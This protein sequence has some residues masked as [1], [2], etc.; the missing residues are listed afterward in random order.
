MCVCVCVC[1][2]A[3]VCM[4]YLGIFPLSFFR[5]SQVK[6]LLN[7]SY[8]Y[9]CHSCNLGELCSVLHSLIT[10]SA[11]MISLCFK[12]RLC[13]IMVIVVF[14]LI[15]Q[16]SKKLCINYLFILSKLDSFGL[17]AAGV[18]LLAQHWKIPVLRTLRQKL[19]AKEKEPLEEETKL[20]GRSHHGFPHLHL[21]NAGHSRVVSVV[22]NTVL[23]GHHIMLLFYNALCLYSSHSPSLY[24]SFC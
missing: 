1:A 9:S 4:L 24:F 15:L 13:L 19:L 8:P 22:T 6:T 12:T 3:H 5:M 23:R 20:S 16:P 2:R 17:V 10:R 7:C 14:R 18:S 11:I 21:H